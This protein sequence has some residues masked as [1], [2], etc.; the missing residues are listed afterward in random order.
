MNKLY[1][2]DFV[3]SSLLAGVN[4]YLLKNLNYKILSIL[5]WGVFIMAS[6]LLNYDKILYFIAL[7][8]IGVCVIT[9]YIIKM[10]PEI[11]EFYVIFWL[12]YSISAIVILSIIITKKFMYN[13][14]YNQ[15][16][17]GDKGTIGI[18]GKSGI[19]YNLE[20][21]PDRCYGELISG[22][23]DYLLTNKK[24]N[25]LE[26]NPDEPQLKNLYFKNLLKR[27]CMSEEFGN[28][29]YSDTQSEVCEYNSVSDERVIKGTTRPCI[30]TTQV[31]SDSQA[32]ETRYTTIVKK[33]KNKIIDN[34]NS[35]IKTILKNGDIENKKLYGKFGFNESNYSKEKLD[36]ILENDSNIIEDHKY[37]NK[38][39]HAFINDYFY[40][41]KFFKDVTPN[42]FKNIKNKNK[43]KNKITINGTDFDN[44]YYWGS[45]LN[46]PPTKCSIL[47]KKK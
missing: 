17:P 31:T 20:T 9:I 13:N 26:Y 11:K 16:L 6:M 32:K 4:V 34:N 36:K 18:I 47:F 1:I 28:Y 12:L 7:F 8:M 45:N 30:T 38:K 46:R 21:Y 33:L 5:I 24:S 3:F 22:I 19:S 37:N 41:D 23:E 25:D 42:P 29:I 2:Y 15:P 14:I 40:T 10:I 35:W 43:N 39:G 27:I 44:P